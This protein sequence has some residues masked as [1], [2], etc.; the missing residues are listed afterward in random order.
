[1]APETK[2]KLCACGCGGEAPVYY[3]NGLNKG[4]RKYIKGHQP[5]KPLCD[6]AIREKARATRY[7]RYP[8][9]SRRKRNVK[10]RW[11]WEIKIAG[12]RRWPLEHRYIME[13]RLGRFLLTNEHVHH[14]DNNGLNNG[15]H[16]DGQDNLVLLTASDH[17]RL[18]TKGRRPECTCICPL[19]GARL[20]HF[21][22]KAS[23][24]A[25]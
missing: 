12:R 6:A 21:A 24:S 3:L 5:A 2:T 17:I 20:P 23:D 18:H 22:K 13:Q 15:L 14:R 10:G 25:P 7:A 11:Y 19:C 1:M 8:V 4:R 9:G 16:A